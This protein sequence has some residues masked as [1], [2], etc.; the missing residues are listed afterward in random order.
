MQICLIRIVFNLSDW[1]IKLH[2]IQWLCVSCWY[3]EWLLCYVI[4]FGSLKICNT[5]E[6]RDRS[7][8]WTYYWGSALCSCFAVAFSWS[9]LM[10]KRVCMSVS[11]CLWK[12]LVI[13][14][15]CYI[16]PNFFKDFIFKFKF[17]DFVYHTLLCNFH[18]SF[19][20]ANFVSKLFNHFILL[21][22]LLLN[23]TQINFLW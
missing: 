10:N 21:F 1:L 13:M 17:C 6:T 12:R 14:T 18:L 16:W 19:S 2:F 4:S 8:Q 20:L 9:L 23:D 7:F 3:I 15:Q 5:C 11:S 22:H